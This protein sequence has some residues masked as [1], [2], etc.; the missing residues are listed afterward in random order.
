M[1]LHNKLNVVAWYIYLRS[2]LLKKTECDVFSTSDWARHVLKSITD[3]LLNNQNSLN[4]LGTNNHD[5]YKEIKKFIDSN[6]YKGLD[7]RIE[8]YTELKNPDDRSNSEYIPIEIN[9]AI[10][11]YENIFFDHPIK[12]V[13]DTI[14]KY[15]NDN[16]LQAEVNQTVLNELWRE[17]IC[18]DGSVY[19]AITG[20][21]CAE[22]MQEVCS[23][24]GKYVE[25]IYFRSTHITDAGKRQWVRL[26][27][28]HESHWD[29]RRF[30]GYMYHP[31]A[32]GVRI[33]GSDI[34]VIFFKKKNIFQNIREI[35]KFVREE[36]NLISTRRSGKYYPHLHFP[37]THLEVKWIAKAI[38][39]ENSIEW[40]N[41][42]NDNYPKSFSIV[43]QE[44]QKEMSLRKDDFCFCI[45]TG[46]VMALHGLRDTKDIDYI[47]V[48]NTEKPIV[49]GRMESHNQQYEGYNKDARE[50]IEN[51]CL[52]FHYKNMK[53]ATLTEVK[54]YKKYRT[55]AF[56]HS[57]SIL[58]DHNDI[59]I[60]DNYINSKS[61]LED[62]IIST[63]DKISNNIDT[64]DNSLIKYRSS[65][66]DDVKSNIF[67]FFIITIK[68]L[69]P[70]LITEK[71]KKIYLE[72]LRLRNRLRK[73][74]IR[75]NI[76][77][78]LG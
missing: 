30:S 13:Q 47:T 18:L 32:Y 24:L 42:A 70:M 20:D 12:K 43:I 9:N 7:E 55:I 61:K 22:A 57:K 10:G 26:Q 2:G 78:I 52:H 6:D 25:I 76:Q 49:N 17:Y 15:D 28:A 46:A 11:I 36:L 33:P 29:E 34:G 59:A 39:N 1:L 51:P 44:Y 74:R 53:F 3:A 48:G 58:K 54:S 56:K 68:K 73:N 75:K 65:I 50:I 63:N 16:L 21:G 41:K 23:V 66:L 8:T 40:M 72:F 14:L 71:L 60:I 77:N 27:Y 67:R 4:Q 31:G 45:D 69:L 38:L 37:D 64:P 35:K 19:A 5:F 62:K